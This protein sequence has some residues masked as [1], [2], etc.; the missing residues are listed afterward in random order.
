MLDRYVTILE[1]VTAV[2]E[3]VSVGELS[4]MTEIP[5]PTCYRLVSALAKTGFATRRARRAGRLRI[6]HGPTRVTG[7]PA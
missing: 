4:R 5:R 6:L 7:A 1:G 2:G 3:P